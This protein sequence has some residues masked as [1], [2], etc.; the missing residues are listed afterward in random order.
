M[1]TLDDF[2]NDI[3]RIDEVLVR[4]LNERARVAVEIGRVKKEKGIEIYQPEREKQVL[5]HVRGV[6]CEGPLGPDAIARLF[7]R[8]IDEARRLERR[9]V[10]GEDGPETARGASS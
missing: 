9:V 1:R 4:L 2:R 7:E 8:I 3:D 6:A 5:A 10:H